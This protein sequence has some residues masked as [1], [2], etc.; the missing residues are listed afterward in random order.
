MTCTYLSHVGL[1]DFRTFGRFELDLAPGPGLTLLVG[2]NGLGKS[3]F[4]DAVEWG[5]TGRIRRFVDHAGG[6]PEENYLTRRDAQPGSHGVTLSFDDGATFTRAAGKAPDADELLTSLKDPKWG[7]I[8]DLASYLALTHFLG[9]AAQQRFTS[10]KQADQWEALK[11]PSGIDRL[12]QVRLAL[13]G[14]ATAAAFR[15]RAAQQSAEV[16]VAEQALARWR[17]RSIRL[18]AL[19][20]AASAAGVPMQERVEADLERLALAVGLDDAT[21]ASVAGGNRG[22]AA[23]SRLIAT[24]RA[25]DATRE[26]LVA[27]TSRIKGLRETA[28]RHAALAAT[29]DLDGAAADAAKEAVERA[30]A[31]LSEASIASKRAERQAADAA[32]TSARAE[33]ALRRSSE[34]AGI[35]G[36]IARL[37]TKAEALRERRDVL[38]GALDELGS[39]DLANR[40]ALEAARARQAARRSLFQRAEQDEEILRHLDRLATAA[41]DVRTAAAAAALAEQAA[42]AA[43]GAVSADPG[44]AALRAEI[45]A[46]EADLATARRRAT[47]MADAVATVAKHVGDHDERCPICTSAFPPGVL[48]RLAEAA[49]LAED[50]ELAAIARRAE[51]AA[52]ALEEA[53]AA[54]AAASQAASRAEAAR[55]EAARAEA[56]YDAARGRLAALLG[57]NPDQDLAGTAA[58][59]AAATSAELAELDRLDADAGAGLTELEDAGEAAA[60]ARA[61]LATELAAVEGDQ[62]AAAVRASQLNLAVASEPGDGDSFAG[63]TGSDRA[64]LV[65]SREREADARATLAGTLSLEAAARDRLDRAEVSRA[66]TSRAADDARTERRTLAAEW[67]AAGLAGE[68]SEQAV[69]DHAMALARRSAEAETATAEADRLAQALESLAALAELRTLE[70]ELRHEAGDAATSDPIAHERTLQLRLDEARGALAATTQTREAV[71][72]YT[73]QLKKEADSFSSRFL[74]PLNEL[75]DDFNKTL[76][77]TPGETVQFSA[78]AAVNRTAFGMRLLYADK[79]DNS[80]YDTELAPQLVLSEGQMAANGFS[81]LCAASVAYPWSSWRA[82]LLDDP[83][84]HNDII[85]AAAFA[86]VMRNLVEYEG[87]QLLMSSHD[88]AEGEFMYRKFDAAGLPVTM[89]NLTAPSREGVRFAEPRRN[90]AASRLLAGPATATA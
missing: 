14:P 85:H 75:I 81:I 61:A 21:G 18:R 77:S 11:G 73:E 50:G 62:E 19:H 64:A 30:V 65:A 13:R 43:R 2:P 22:L 58:A 87:Y 63:R 15:R 53:E 84:Q 72:A 42:E 67:A 32:E 26:R 66:Q 69:T 25:L 83:L 7:G 60:R 10:R 57:V 79:V 17:E 27:E 40:T 47:E 34:L 52:R 28:T 48:R 12:E 41:A 37:T 9:Q 59:R 68:P 38:R 55:A 46:A 6:L 5:L 29:A 44:I 8:G 56:T 16:D 70:A 20:T 74:M 71:N 51:Q 35:A 45:T 31:D 23:T 4:F 90:A 54:I 39:R 3:S 86:D 36:E 78:D 33:E 80:R 24:R 76:L 49:A 89:V 82:L 88:R 1:T